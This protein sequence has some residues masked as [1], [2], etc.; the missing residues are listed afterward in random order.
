MS[1]INISAA[2]TADPGNIWTPKSSFMVGDPFAIVLNVQVDSSVVN[3]GLLFDALF[4][5]V[6]PQQ[7]PY[8]GA[9]WT[10]TG[11]DVLSMDSVDVPWNGVSFQWGTNFAIWESWSHYSDAV[12]QIG[13]PSITGVYNVQG[14]VNVEGSDLFAASSPFWFKTR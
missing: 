14:S 1:F 4:Q 11:S 3:E 6:N 2:Y 8:G 13:G 9:W 7:D 12:S 5:I 10:F